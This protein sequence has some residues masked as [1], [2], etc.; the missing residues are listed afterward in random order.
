[1]Q[2]NCKDNLFRIHAV[3]ANVNSSGLELWSVN[4]TLLYEISELN[5]FKLFFGEIPKDFSNDLFVKNVYNTLELF[6]R[7][8]K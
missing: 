8:L 5:V 2:Q 6:L 3:L 4:D 1:M 7:R